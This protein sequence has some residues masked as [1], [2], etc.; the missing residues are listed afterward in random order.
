MIQ[1]L[2]SVIFLLFNGNSTLFRTSRTISKYE[3]SQEVEDPKSTRL[4]YEVDR[5]SKVITLHGCN[6]QN[7]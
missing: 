3:K 7:S 6:I 1:E 4:T 5:R 2:N